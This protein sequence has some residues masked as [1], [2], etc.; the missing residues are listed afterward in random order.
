MGIEQRL[1]L[2]ST[3]ADRYDRLRIFGKFEKMIDVKQIITEKNLSLPNFLINWLK[4]II[5]QSEI[6]YFLKKNSGKIGV[7]FMSAILNDFNI[8]TKISGLDNI[9]HGEKLIFA[10]NHPLGALEAMAIGTVLGEQFYNKINFVTNDLLTFLEPLKPIFTPVSVG[11]GKQNKMLAEDLDKTFS[12]DNQIIMFPSGTVS[13]RIR[14]K[15]QDPEWK[16]MFVAK[17]RQYERNVVPI[18][19]MGRS[20]NFFLNLSNF[21]KFI[22][23]KTNIELLFLPN[24][25]FKKKNSE[26]CITIGKPISYKTF[27]KEK[28][29][30]EWAQ[31]VR[32]KVYL[33]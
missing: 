29:D 19:C 11:V 12:S 24:E 14:G 13:R 33:L 3:R 30:F 17:A 6:N 9:A 2:Y 5:H 8:K 31:E 25:M 20:S 26:I 27:T 16:K 4:K 23:I 1:H 7:D 21:R 32:K 10:S 22:G 15:V 28:S 18:F